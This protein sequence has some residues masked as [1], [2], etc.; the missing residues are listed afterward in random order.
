MNRNTEDLIARVMAKAAVAADYTAKKTG[1][2]VNATKLNYK[3]MEINGRIDAC[4]RAIG[5]AVYAA[6]CGEEADPAA[7]DAEFA[8][9]DA[10]HAEAEETQRKITAAKRRKLCRVCGKANPQDARYC[11][12]CGAEL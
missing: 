5:R 7:L 4:E 12:E 6:H 9:L 11:I 1:E 2:V 8:A 3:L 10:L